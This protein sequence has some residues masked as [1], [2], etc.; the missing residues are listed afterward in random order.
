MT[1]LN[2]AVLDLLD[3]EGVDDPH[4]QVADE[5]ISDDLPAWEVFQS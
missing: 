5:Q 2:R 4:G 1:D 3:L